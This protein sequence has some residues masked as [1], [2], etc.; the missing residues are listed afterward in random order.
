MDHCNLWAVLIIKCWVC[1]QHLLYIPTTGSLIIQHQ[2]TCISRYLF[3][4]LRGIKCYPVLQCYS[5]CFFS[6]VFFLCCCW[7]FW[8]FFKDDSFYLAIH[9]GKRRAHSSLGKE[10]RHEQTMRIQKG[11]S[12]QERL[13]VV[14]LQS[15]TGNGHL[16]SKIPC[17]REMKSGSDQ[18]ISLPSRL[19]VTTS[20]TRKSPA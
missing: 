8:F 5:P 3:S 15:K 7:G 19:P 9:A 18:H 16:T 1:Y 17:S 14:T 13:A 10:I 4:M 12:S 6:V 2:G 11:E 20:Q